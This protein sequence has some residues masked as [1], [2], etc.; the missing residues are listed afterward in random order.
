MISARQVAALFEEKGVPPER[1][2]IEFVINTFPFWGRWRL[3]P[4][5]G[6]Q[7]AVM[8]TGEALLIPV[9]HGEPVEAI[10]MDMIEGRDVWISYDHQDDQSKTKAKDLSQLIRYSLRKP[11][12]AAFLDKN[13][14][15]RV[16]S[17]KGWKDLT[18]TLGK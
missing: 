4:D 16:L 12:S 13:S 10:D 2:S 14:H 7:L 17:D 1:Q 6:E 11:R 15:Y 8:W 5:D 9:P 18:P 3:P